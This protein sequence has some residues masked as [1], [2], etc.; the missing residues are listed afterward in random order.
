MK[1]RPKSLRDLKDAIK[2]LNAKKIKFGEVKRFYNEIEE[3]EKFIEFPDWH[4]KTVLLIFNGANPESLPEKDEI[5]EKEKIQETMGLEI[6]N[7]LDIPS[8][9]AQPSKIFKKV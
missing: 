2:D 6:S 5:L 9:S 3:P 4:P 1:S 8:Y 7:I